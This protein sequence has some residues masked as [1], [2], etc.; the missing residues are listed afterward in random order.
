MGPNGENPRKLYETDEKSSIR[1]VNWSADGQRIVYVRT[2]EAGHTFLSR[3]LKGGPIATILTPPVTKTVRDF[4]WLPDGRFVY[5]VE[6][7]DSYLGTSCNFWTLRTD[8]KSGQPIGHPQQLTKWSQSCLTGLSVTADGRSL[9]F[10]KWASHMTSYVAELT[11]DNT[12]IDNP[13][14]FPLTAGSDGTVDWTPDSGAVFFVSNRLGRYG[15]YRQALGQETAEPVLTEGY[16]R[17]PRVAPDG[18]NIVYLGIGENGMWP[19]RGP[20]PVMRV[21]VAGGA[22][23]RLFVAK[24]DSL[25]SCARSPSQL[26]AIA[27]RSEDRRQKT[28]TAFDPAKGRGSVLLQVPLDPKEDDEWTEIS[29]MAHASPCLSPQPDPSTSIRF[30]GKCCKRFK[31]RDGATSR[32][33]RGPRTERACL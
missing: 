25:I 21:S 31:S 1:C 19:A 8:S 15:I 28:V 9:A 16:G 24:F 2:D 18:Q 3:D 12:R 23:E 22:S 32:T 4:L 29:P 17:N 5:S 20:E 13:R 6:E 26:C 11:K 7:P 10:L 14:Q 33:L 30:A 27:E